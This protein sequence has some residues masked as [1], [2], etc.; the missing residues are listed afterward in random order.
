MSEELQ[1]DQASL[2]AEER[3]KFDLKYPDE[4]V[5]K[6]LYKNYKSGADKT[7]L[8]FGCGSGRNTMVMADLDFN[9]IAMDY[10]DICLDLTKEKLDKRNYTKVQYS[11]NKGN[12][13]PVESTS[14][15]CVVIWGTIFINNYI[16]REQIMS[17]LSRV[18]KPSGLLLV[19]FRT[20]ED[21]LY[22]RGK[23]LEP[24][25][26]LLD[27]AVGSLA[28]LNYWFA[29]NKDAVELLHKHD[30]D[31]INIEKKDMY[32]DNL[33]TKHSHWHIWARKKDI[34]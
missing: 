12:E 2:W 9:I 7:I 29:S 21:N 13:I 30:F 15:D 3:K 26:F 32:C 14:V 33:S 20:Q 6:F 19:D 10:N 16:D 1:K 17:E 22:K 5:I 4:N 31:I 27:E 34:L 23:E 28:G 25:F 8:D 18:L 24:N 11:K